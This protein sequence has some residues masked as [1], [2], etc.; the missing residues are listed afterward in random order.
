[1]VT[2]K[3]FWSRSI[4]D[5]RVADGAGMQR[6]VAIPSNSTVAEALAAIIEFCDGS[7]AACVGMVAEDLIDHGT[8][9]R[10]AASHDFLDELRRTSKLVN[11]QQ[12]PPDI[13]PGAHAPTFVVLRFHTVLVSFHQSAV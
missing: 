4:C 6:T 3:Y 13:F 10:D 8:E 9:I 12:A 1:M 7:G 11:P 5:S 2:L